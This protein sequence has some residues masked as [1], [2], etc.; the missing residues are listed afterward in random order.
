MK[1]IDTIFALVSGRII[2][3][4]FSDLL[5]G[6][7]IDLGMYNLL[8]AWII[9]P[10]ISLICLWIAFLIGKKWLFAFQ[11]AKFLLVGA[12]ATVLDLKFF[13]LLL[14]VPLAVI[15]L[16]GVSFIVATVLKYVGNKY[17]TFQEYQ[18]FEAAE[19]KQENLGLEIAQFIVITIIGTIIDVVSFYYFTHI[20][21][22]PVAI[23][24][25]VWVKLSVIFAAI[26]AASF[27]FLGYKFLVFKK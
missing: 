21:G 11:S 1:L 14:I 13:E 23:N 12:V 6:W 7:G 16:K 27:N 9:F 18:P 3:I 10:F 4:I 20:M 5:I 26:V 25:V 8:I 15:F 22:A 24:S 2:W 17:W 19:G